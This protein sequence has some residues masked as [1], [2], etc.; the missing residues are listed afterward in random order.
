MSIFHPLEIAVRSS[1]T[2]VHWVTIQINKLT[3]QGVISPSK[4]VK[5][6]FGQQK[7]KKLD[8]KLTYKYE[9]GFY[10]DETKFQVG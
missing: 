6:V 1:E 7:L 5:F 4:R 10:G 9:V 2:Q 3:G 8:L